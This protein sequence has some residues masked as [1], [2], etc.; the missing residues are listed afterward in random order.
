MADAI[1]TASA[2]EH[3][4]YIAG[5]STNK[6]LVL[7][8]GASTTLEGYLKQTKAQVR[9]LFYEPAPVIKQATGVEN[10][11]IVDAIN[12]LPHGAA[13]LDGKLPPLGIH[14]QKLLV[15]QGQSGL[16]AFLG[17]MD[18]DFSRID[19]N[20]AAGLPYHDT[21]LRIT[22]PA[23]LECR[24]VF[25]DRWLDHHSTPVLDQKLGA[26]A[27]A[28]TEQRRTLA[29]PTPVT[30]APQDIPSSTYVNGSKRAKKLGLRVAVGRT[31]ASSKRMGGTAGYGF[32]PSG[33]YSAWALIEQGIIQ[34]T[35]W[36]YLEDQYMVSRM[37][38]KLLLAKLAQPGFEFLLIL[39]NESDTAARDFRFLRTA[40]NEFRRDLM[41][42][43]PKKTRW[44]M[45][46][47][48]NPTDPERQKWCGAYVHSKTWIF[49]DGYAVIGSA[50]SDNRGYT[51]DSEIV[52]GI[53]EETTL[54]VHLG[55][56]FATD[57]R[58]RLWHKHLGLPHA[59]LRDWEKAIN[60]WKRP[61]PTAM[62]SD[63]S[64]FEPDRDLVPPSNFPSSTDAVNVEFLWTTLIDPDAR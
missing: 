36:I 4:I 8:T 19:V 49:D 13:V 12:A 23:A 54:P 5:W 9:G 1:Q 40:R 2:P 44:G 24:K 38:R 16:I 25:E 64:A 58:T 22:G 51:Y 14:H 34:A 6:D 48:R 42:V 35:K 41:A 26:T 11:W 7:K 28:T 62:I 63:A 31:F 52:A 32:A 17:G 27:T 60:F 30:L 33:D 47:L 59:Q 10:R 3:R 43:D 57:L 18:F 46:T 29:F 53:A 56:S 45:Y 37:A 61:P 21:Q 15:V 39:M 20:P 50:N 55:E